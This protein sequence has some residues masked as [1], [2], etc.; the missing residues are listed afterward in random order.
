[1]HYYIL[2]NDDKDLG[3]KE[4]SFNFGKYMLI[5]ASRPGTMAAALQG[6]WNNKYTA[7]WNGTYQLD[8][9]VTQ[10]YM[11]GNAL[12]LAE[13]QEPII[14]YTRMLS[15]VGTIAAARFYGS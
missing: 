12:N 2:N 13:C 11:F 15:Q 3:L 10:T 8:M 4:L 14:D 6:T 7:L 1:M 9:N 5:S